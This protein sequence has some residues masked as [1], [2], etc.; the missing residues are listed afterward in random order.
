MFVICIVVKD[1][2]IDFD[3]IIQRRIV[4]YL[5]L[6]GETMRDIGLFH[7]KM[8]L[9]VA[10]YEY[11]NKYGDD[12]ICD[13][14]WEL[15]EQV[16]CGLHIDMP[17][18]MENGFVGI[19]YG[20]TVLQQKGWFDVDLN[21]VLAD[22]DHMIMMRDPR[23]ITDVSLRRGLAGIAAYLKARSRFATG[24]LTFDSQYISELKMALD[25]YNVPTPDCGLC[26]MIYPPTFSHA[27]FIGKPLDIDQ[28]CAYYLLN[29]K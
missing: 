29:R 24:L 8:G 3:Y 19:G 5:L 23:R 28:G 4:D 6:H 2:L 27:D 20:V 9:V 13:Y 10:L 17:I 11:A 21:E 16:Y 1:S 18:G 7:G 15:L 22:V 26:E 12:L 14:A 25:N